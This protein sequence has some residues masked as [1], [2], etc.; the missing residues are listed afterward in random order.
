M[1]FC[2]ADVFECLK[3]RFEDAQP[4]FLVALYRMGIMNMMDF[5]FF[6]LFSICLM[7]KSDETKSRQLFND[8]ENHAYASVEWLVFVGE[9]V[10]SLC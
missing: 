8:L 6:G 2:E 7:L 5:C 1:K 10:S 4:Y 3:I 9:M